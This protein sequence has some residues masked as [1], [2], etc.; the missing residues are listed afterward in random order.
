MCSEGPDITPVFLVPSETGNCGSETSPWSFLHL[1]KSPWESCHRE[2]SHS[3]THPSD[4]TSLNTFH[5]TNNI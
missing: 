2:F 4:Q 1:S 3:P 5:C